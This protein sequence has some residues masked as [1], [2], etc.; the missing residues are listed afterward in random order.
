MIRFATAV[1]ASLVV[2]TALSAA[3]QVRAAPQTQPSATG[4]VVVIATVEAFWSA[5]QYG[6]TAGYVA[7]VKHDLGDRVTKGEVLAVLHV[8]ELEKNLVQAK[9]NLSAKEQMRKAAEAAVTQAQQAL[10][11]ARSQLA[12][13]QAERELQQVTL[14]RQEELSAGKATTPQQL[15]EIRSKSKVAEAN[16]LTGQAK[17][18]SAEADVQA[19]GAS[20]DVAAAQVDVASAGVQEVEALL[21]YT[22]IT[23]PFDG[24]VT[25][26]QVN[27]G[28]LVQAAT[29][30]RTMP[31]FTVQQT[32]TVRVFCEVPEAQA[33]GVAAGAETDVKLFGLGGQVI[34]GKVTR[35]AHAIDPT[36]RTMRAEIDLPNPKG[37]LQPG[38]YAQVT[39]A[40]R[41]S[42]RVADAA[43]AH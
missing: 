35:T 10:S 26:R 15:D 11:V 18:G 29:T 7:E 4:T 22:K 42:A 36:S 27:P 33:A 2:L 14:K 6:K 31:L 9:A 19:A 28:D 3:A 24:I 37:T 34:K 5:D 25:R 8:P 1:D 12:A 20:R 13:L 23:A 40:L 38:M 17:V 32:D 30:N 39:I 41:E 21:E 16:A 43:P